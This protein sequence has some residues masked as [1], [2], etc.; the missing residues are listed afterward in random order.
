MS[1]VG[2]EKV[3]RF[4][5]I[6]LGLIALSAAVFW[7]AHYFV[8]PAVD[9]VERVSWKASDE[10]WVATGQESLEPL[11]GVHY[12][13]DLLTLRGWGMVWNPYSDL[14]A[15]PGQHLPTGQLSLMLL[16]A[17]PSQIL[18]IFY[19]VFSVAILF[20]A[21]RTL[22]N[23]ILRVSFWKYT[24]LFLVFSVLSIPMLVDLDR[25]NVQSVAL[26][27]T[28]FFFAYGLRGKWVVAILWLLFA[29]SLKPYLLIF[30][31]AFL[32]K[33]NFRT[34]ALMGVAFCSL[35]VLLMQAFSGN[36]L[37]GF[38]SMWEANARY[39][40]S[41]FS[42][43][44][45]SN[46][47]SL[48]GSAHRISEFAFGLEFSNKLLLEVLWVVPIISFLLV[49]LGMLIWYRSHL[50]IWVRL[51]G[52]LSIITLAQPGSAAY[53]WGWVGVVVIVFLLDK[54]GRMPLNT[55]DWSIWYL[56]V[57]AALALVPTWVSLPSLSGDIRQNMSYLILSP[58]VFAGLVYWAARSYRKSKNVESALELET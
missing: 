15:L 34:H 4:L 2:T 56:Q 43:P 3:D 38:R 8:A 57:V 17:I 55:A 50:P 25:G 1:T 48:V 16:A 19:L 32:S 24:Q 35:N 42:L 20:I 39:T 28:I 52:A 44:F 12:F 7:T 40:S 11:V 13:G 51:M 54:M 10:P 26:A 21:I 22:A 33:R 5:T 58:I 45:I 49:V 41:E 46:A 30:S 9:L 14:L 18:L 31:I 23:S 36:F 37:E 47:G 27:G 6:H 53:N 29:A